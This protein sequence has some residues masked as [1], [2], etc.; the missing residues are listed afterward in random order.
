MNN[1]KKIKTSPRPVILA[2]LAVI[3]L[4]FGGLGAW[5]S[6]FPISGA[7]IA[8]GV[9][10]VSQE[11]KS[12]QHLE[13]GIVERI[14]VRDGDFVENGDLLLELRSIRVVANV[15][16]IRGQLMIN[17]AEAARLRAQKEELQTIVWPDELLMSRTEDNIAREAMEKELNVFNSSL[18]SLKSRIAMLDNQVIQLRERI[19][20]AREEMDAQDRIINA[21]REEL[22]AKEELARGNYIDM[23][24]ILALR[25]ALAESEGR[26]G[27]LRQVIAESREQI[28][29]KELTKESLR[30]EYREKATTELSRVE[31][32]IFELRKQLRPS[33][34]QQERLQVRAP[35]SGDIVNMQIHSEDGGVIMPGETILEIVPRGAE[36]VVECHIR[37]DQ[38]TKVRAGQHVRLELAAFNRVT[39]PPVDGKLIWISADRVEE[40]TP[41]G[42]QTFYKAHVKVDEESLEKARAYISPGMPATAFITTEER[43]FLSYLIEPI[44]LNLDRAVRERM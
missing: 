6:F 13:G 8:P 42:R 5:A 26:R 1:H 11:R 40:D 22:E 29:E 39:T 4:F 32:R 7:V 20:G 25:R 12:V 31:D 34:D 37:E 27:S 14:L 17:L 35:V 24:Q 28:Q 23:G 30:S 15:D 41:Q 10:K 33:L 16:L 2:G 19:E 43:T 18:H 38:I 3:I 21:L 44:L 36:L 9:V